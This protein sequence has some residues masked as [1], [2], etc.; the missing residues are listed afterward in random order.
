MRSVFL[1]VLAAVAAVSAQTI[2]NVGAEMNSPGGIFQFMPNT[3]TAANGTVVTFRFS[4]IP[5]NHSVTQSSFATPC[6]PMAGGFDSGWINIQQNVSTAG[7]VLPEWNLTITNDATPIWF[8]CKQL[9]PAPHCV[10]GMVGVI[11][12]QPGANSF[13]SFRANAAAATSAPPGQGQGGL[14]GVGASA[15]AA[16][17]VP[18]SGVTNIL[19][20]SASATAP[21]GSGGATGASGAPTSSGSG[22]PSGAVPIGLNFNIL[23]VFGGVLA[24]AALIL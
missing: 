14:I 13:S 22:T 17:L 16:P 18:A 20:A 3:I 6:E 1:V 8:Y 9:L 11:N 2:V 24:G 15:S 19:G 10:A 12:V 7:E 5:G 4:G 23:V 21:G